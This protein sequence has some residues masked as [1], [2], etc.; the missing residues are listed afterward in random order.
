MGREARRKG[1][2]PECVSAWVLLGYNDNNNKGVTTRRTR[3][4][5]AA[6]AAAAIGPKG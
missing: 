1:M 3:G 6:A 4:A 5:T 2:V